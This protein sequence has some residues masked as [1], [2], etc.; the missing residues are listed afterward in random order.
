MNKS[1][2]RIAFKHLVLPLIADLLLFIS[3]SYL[4]NTVKND[5]VAL[6][7]QGLLL[8]YVLLFLLIVLG[9]FLQWYFVD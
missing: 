1:F 4:V 8:L 7:E 6:N 2:R 9:F 3:F 5:Y